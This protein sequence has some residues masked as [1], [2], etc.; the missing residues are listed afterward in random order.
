MKGM[1][2][3]MASDRRESYAGKLKYLLEK[4][5]FNTAFAYVTTVKGKW[6]ISMQFSKG[7]R[8]CCAILPDLFPGMENH[9][10]PYVKYLINHGL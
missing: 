2:T 10:G 3:K 9:F 4:M 1:A 6:N 8:L 7:M 5:T